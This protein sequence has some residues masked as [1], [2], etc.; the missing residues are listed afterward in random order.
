MVAGMLPNDTVTDKSAGNTRRRRSAGRPVRRPGGPR[1]RGSKRLLAQLENLPQAQNA[2]DHGYGLKVLRG[3]IVVGR[4]VFLAVARHY[5]DLLSAEQRGLM[6]S[7]GH[8]WHIIDFIERRFVHIRGPLARRPILLD[9]WQ[10]F[11][12]A[13]LYGWRRADTGLRRF[14]TGYE[15]VA[16]KNGKSTWKGPQAAYLFL[17]DGEV[18]AEVY[19]IAT[20]RE[21]AMAIFKPALDNIR[22]WARLSPGVDRSFKIHDGKNQEQIT[23]DS[24]VFKPLP[25]NAES[26]DGLNPS[27]TMVDELHAH[28]TPDVWEVMESAF[29]ARSQPLLSAITTAGF[30]L[31]GICV[32]VRTY[33]IRVLEGTIENDAFF[34][35]VYTL[36]EGD[37]PF[38]ERVWVKANPGLGTAKSVEYMRSVAL[39]AAALPSALAN[40]KTKDLNI[41]CNSADGWLDIGMWDK[42]GKKF[43]PLML[44]GRRCFGG[45]DLS[46]TRD[47]TALSLVFPPEGD[48]DEWHVLVWTF[49]PRET[50]IERSK[51]DAAAYAQWEKR[52]YL[53]VTDGNVTD[54]EPMRKLITSL[55]NMYDLVE[56]AF[57]KWN[58]TH[59]VNQ[60]GEAGIPLVEVPQ[61]TGGMH[62]GSKLLEELVYSRRLRHGGN[63]VL[64][65]AAGNISL[66]FDSN[67]NFR[68]D[69][70][71]SRIKGRI[72]PLVATIMALS[73]A[74]VH[75][76][77]DFSGYFQS[78][79]GG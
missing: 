5:M 36:D 66:L 18:G 54:Y 63:P 68:P 65:W 62:P 26:L 11:W 50:V 58:A 78:A 38:D 64:R 44:R 48:D 67:G 25:A 8:A 43:D 12:T 75:V 45:M 14:R 40:Y 21:Q 15:E 32:D 49:C 22:R 2:W 79:V 6:F 39:K 72:D 7:A 46:A 24:S 27:A 61:N 1:E 77:V 35:Y 47:L 31:E 4:L 42:G 28:R 33:L 13:V 59:L 9:P 55:P 57:D 10:Q 60:L 71:L 34:G 53:T 73:R 20:T 3:Q 70:K 51:D 37:D 76:N 16:R 17:M 29:G 52:G 30:I 41:W 56:L 74:S 23:F 69:K 19:T